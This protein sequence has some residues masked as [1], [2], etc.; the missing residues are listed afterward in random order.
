MNLF[1]VADGFAA[2]FDSVE[3]VGPQLFDILAVGL[4]QPGLFMD[5][6]RLGVDRI[7]RP[8]VEP[9][10]MKSSVRPVEITAH[11]LGRMGLL[12]IVAGEAPMFPTDGKVLE[13]VDGNLMVGRVGCLGLLRVDGRTGNLAPA[14]REDLPWRALAGDPENLVYP[15]NAPIAQSSVG[16]IEEVAKASGMNALV[17]GAQRGGAA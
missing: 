15:M 16:V 17:E 5:R 9:S 3:E 6:R 4:I 7:E 10:H 13:L 12:G 11:G 14:G 8:T 2:G 1:D